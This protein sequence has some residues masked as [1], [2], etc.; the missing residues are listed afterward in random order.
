MEYLTSLLNIPLAQMLGF[1]FVIA[2]AQKLGIPVVEIFKW[3]FTKNGNGNGYKEQI[4]K[5]EIEIKEVKE[6][7]LAHLQESIT[8]IETKVDIILKKLKL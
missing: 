2:L 5:L 3:M 6:N 4:N 8:R 1:I 7:H